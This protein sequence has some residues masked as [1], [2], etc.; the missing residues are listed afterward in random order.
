[1]SSHS[2]HFVA[3]WKDVFDNLIPWSNFFP[4]NHL[5]RKNRKEYEKITD[6]SACRFS[7]NGEEDLR[8]LF[9]HCPTVALFWQPVAGR[10]SFNFILL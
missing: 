10:N 3:Y 8:Q 6:D 5:F 4:M 9:L 1:M 2:H 7:L